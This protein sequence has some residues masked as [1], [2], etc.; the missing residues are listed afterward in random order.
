MPLR[1]DD[2][3]LRAKVAEVLNRFPAAGLALGIV[4]DGSL[5]CSTATV[6]PT[7]PCRR[8]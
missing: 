3:T 1:V 6:W 8:P 4:G 7:S 2:R 5:G